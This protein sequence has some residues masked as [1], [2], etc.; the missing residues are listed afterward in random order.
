MVLIMELAECWSPATA[1]VQ[2]TSLVDAL[3]FGPG[4]WDPLLA[5]GTAASPFMSW[6]W[7]RAWADSAPPAEL[8]ASQV[9]RLHGVDGSLQ[10]LLPVRMC[11]VRFHRVW[12]RAMSWAI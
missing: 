7:H 9:V 10:A 3:A 2:W 11:R 4:A 6:A 8:D 1:G 12:V 5:H